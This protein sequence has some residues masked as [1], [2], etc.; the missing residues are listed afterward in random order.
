MPSPANA[1]N[2]LLKKIGANNLANICNH[3]N[4]QILSFKRSP[5]IDAFDA[6]FFKTDGTKNCYDSLNSTRDLWPLN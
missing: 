6:W 2:I 3:V 4:L 5:A 1:E